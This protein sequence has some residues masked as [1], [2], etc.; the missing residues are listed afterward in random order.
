[1]LTDSKVDY[2]ITLVLLILAEISTLVPISQGIYVS[3]AYDREIAWLSDLPKLVNPNRRRNY[4][5]AD[6][7]VHS[8]SKRYGMEDDLQTLAISD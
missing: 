7:Q 4:R 6:L 3:G 1:M 8:L 2:Y 5:L